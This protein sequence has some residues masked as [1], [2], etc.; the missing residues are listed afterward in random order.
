MN[1]KNGKGKYIFQNGDKYIGDWEDDNKTGYGIYHFGTGKW[2][3]DRLV[4]NR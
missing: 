4:S 2:D 3:G 1:K